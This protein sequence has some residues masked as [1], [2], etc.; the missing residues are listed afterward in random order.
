M[1]ESTKLYGNKLFISS[2]AKQLKTVK[3]KMSSNVIYRADVYT[4][5]KINKKMLLNFRC[6]D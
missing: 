3:N 5:A 2:H 1:A 4:G 6:M